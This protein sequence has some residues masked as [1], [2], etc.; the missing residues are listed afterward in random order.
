MNSS[1]VSIEVSS[2]PAP[3]GR[4]LLAFL[5]DAVL[6]GTT[7]LFLFFVLGINTL[8]IGGTFTL[9]AFYSVL[10]WAFTGSS[11]GKGL[12]GLRLVTASHGL[13]GLG[14]AIARFVV[15]A[16]LSVFWIAWSTCLFRNDRRAIHDLIG[17]T[18]LV[19]QPRQFRRA[20]ET[21]DEL[22]TT[23]AG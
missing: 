5:L 16:L 12:L 18:W 20:E 6:V 13:P 8:A 21:V 10:L 11:I 17:G 19:Y 15:M 7:D 1:P 2:L 4:R 9:F 14:R 23:R 22:T 3:H